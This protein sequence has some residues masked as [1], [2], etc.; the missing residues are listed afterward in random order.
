MALASSRTAAAETWLEAFAAALAGGDPHAVVSLFDP[1]CL[2]RDLVAFTWNL[3]TEE[4]PEAIT[5]RLAARLADVAPHSFSLR[6]EASETDG[7]IEAWFGF[8]TGWATA[9]A[10]CGCRTVAPGPCLPHWMN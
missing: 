4:G 3:R 6:G 8:E 7:R 10:T 1:E 2:W 9:A 5:A